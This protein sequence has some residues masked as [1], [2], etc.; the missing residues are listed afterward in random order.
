MTGLGGVT[1]LSHCFRGRGQSGASHGSGASGEG[2]GQ[3]LAPNLLKFERL[4]R[5]VAWRPLIRPSGTFSPQ[6]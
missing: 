2:E 4:V 5:V 1:S 6:P 3:Q